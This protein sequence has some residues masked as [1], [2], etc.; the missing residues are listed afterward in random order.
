MVVRT[1]AG[2]SSSAVARW[3]FH[4]FSS[5]VELFRVHVARRIYPALTVTGSALVAVR[6]IW[7]VTWHLIAP[8]LNGSIPRCDIF[9]FAARIDIHYL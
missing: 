4:L 6:A 3:T 8:I 2:L 7:I 9:V 1:S 5:H